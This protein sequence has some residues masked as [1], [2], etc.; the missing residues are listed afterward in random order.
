MNNVRE[1]L[2]KLNEVVWTE[3]VKRDERIKGILS[4]GS[5]IVDV[6]VSL[7]TK[8]NNRGG[9]RT[10]PFNLTMHVSINECVVYSWGCEDIEAQLVMTEWFLKRGVEAHDFE[11]AQKDRNE[12]KAN[13]IFHKL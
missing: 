6:E 8:I 5:S 2:S 10:M 3:D 11:M 4:D 13:L 9:E 12:A 1:F 7:R